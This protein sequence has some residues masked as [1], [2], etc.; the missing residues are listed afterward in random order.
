[1]THDFVAL[2]G[3]DFVGENVIHPDYCNGVTSLAGDF[4]APTRNQ[5]MKY[6]VQGSS[7]LLALFP[8]HSFEVLLWLVEC[9]TSIHFLYVFVCF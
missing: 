9:T 5:G 8:K 3:I 6:T 2:V 1:M 7:S 4:E